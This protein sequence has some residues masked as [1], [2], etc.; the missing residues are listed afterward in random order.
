[1][2]ALFW[3]SGREAVADYGSLLWKQLL[4]LGFNASEY[5][6]K[7]GIR[8]PDGLGPRMFNSQSPNRPGLFCILH[9]LFSAFSPE[10]A[11]VRPPKVAWTRANHPRN[12]I[13]P[14]GLLASG[15]GSGHRPRPPCIFCEL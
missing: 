6:R 12:L 5:A 3:S 4:L 1:M 8:D 10:F 14:F 7:E 9:F 2:S 11:K 15:P 13:S